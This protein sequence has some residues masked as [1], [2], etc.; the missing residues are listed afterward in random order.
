[1][2]DAVCA[3]VVTYNR[4]DLLRICLHSLLQQT[5]PIDRILV[6]NNA[7]T[8]STGELVRSEFPSLELLELK[9][10][11]GGAG[12]F[13][14]G[15]QWAYERGYEWIWV[16]DDDIEMK[17]E[18]LEK[19]LSYQHLGDLIQSRKQ[20][21]WGP[22]IWEAIWDASSATPITYSQDISF[23]N[24]KQ[25]TAIQYSNFEGALIRRCVIERAGLPDERYFIA[26]D[27]TVY[28]YIASLHASVIYI[29]YVGV[30]KQAVATA[31]R[32]RMNYYLTIRNR[33]LTYDHL[34]ANGVPLRRGIFLF[35]TFLFGMTSVKDALR[36][37]K[38]RWQN[39]NAVLDGVR[40]GL[41]R[42]FGRPPWL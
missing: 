34:V 3:V 18:C 42:R 8:D 27:D 21:P 31:N 19:M 36:S 15:M 14:A 29:N 23:A 7:S 12:G 38:N 30:V 16:M 10:N 28:G 37:S 26:G 32:G 13:K 4:K 17:P 1:M 6:V 2:S 22:L 5:R 11:S 25:W 24:G 20:M 35:H 41:G 39:V 40:D 9:I 33:F